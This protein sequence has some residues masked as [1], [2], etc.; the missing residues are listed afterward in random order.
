MDMKKNIYIERS[1]IGMPGWLSGG[2]SA[3][4]SG[5]D[6]GVLGLSPASGSLLSGEPVSPSMS[7]PLGLSCE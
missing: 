7:L 1:E 6:S 4:G 5:R 3:F 2:A